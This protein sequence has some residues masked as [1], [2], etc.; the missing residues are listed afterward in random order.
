MTELER[1]FTAAQTQKLLCTSP[2]Q[3][4]K[5]A[6]DIVTILTATKKELDEL[7]A[8]GSSDLSFKYSIDDDGVGEK[9]LHVEIVTSAS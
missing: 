9:L 5:E 8:S 7:L 2:E 6:K 1:Q 4:S 3:K